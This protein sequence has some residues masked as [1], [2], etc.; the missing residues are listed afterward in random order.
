MPT[1]GLDSFLENNSFPTVS[2]LYFTRAKARRF[3]LLR[4]DILSGKGSCGWQERWRFGN[5]AVP[6][7]VPR[8]TL[9]ARSVEAL[10]LT[11]PEHGVG[12]KNCIP[13]RKIFF[14]NTRKCSYFPEMCAVVLNR[15][16]E[17]L[18]EFTFNF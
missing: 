5:Y 1:P 3:Y 15:T 10:F 12:E 4:E 9:G 14:R 16:A 13:A 8:K 11:F 7:K 18:I 6:K 17:I 2:V